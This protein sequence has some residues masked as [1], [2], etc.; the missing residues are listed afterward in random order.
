VIAAVKESIFEWMDRIAASPHP[1]W[2]L[3]VLASCREL[4]LSDST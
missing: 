4:V 1:G 3:F 2:W